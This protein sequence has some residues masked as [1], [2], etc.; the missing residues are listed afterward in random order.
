MLSV[1]D[2]S[3]SSIKNRMKEANDKEIYLHLH[4]NNGL[5][6]LLKFNGKLHVFLIQTYKW[7]LKTHRKYI[8][9]LVCSSLI[10]IIMGL[11]S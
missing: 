1:P 10:V 6:W 5:K 9:D 2:F 11:A 3:P 4:I 7:T 8:S